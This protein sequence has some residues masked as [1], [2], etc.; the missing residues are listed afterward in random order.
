[1]GTEPNEQKDLLHKVPSE[2]IRSD[3]LEL[4]NGRWV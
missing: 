1:M 3:G 4:R 2:E